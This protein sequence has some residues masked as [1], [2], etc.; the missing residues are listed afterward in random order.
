MPGCLKVLQLTHELAPHTPR[1]AK[2][3]LK[4]SKELPPVHELRLQTFH[5]C[6]RSLCSPFVTSTKDIEL[7]PDLL[8]RRLRLARISSLVADPQVALII[9]GR[10]V[11]GRTTVARTTRASLTCGTEGP[12]I[13]AV[14]LV[15]RLTLARI[16]SLVSP[17]QVA[18]II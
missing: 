16:S 9:E 18:L 17:P 1:L 3:V 7:V 2:L 12:V 4:R 13:A 8:V 6:A 15:R 10:A 11:G 5:V 14:A